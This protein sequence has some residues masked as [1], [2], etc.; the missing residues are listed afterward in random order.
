MLVTRLPP[1]RVR[2]MARKTY[3][4]MFDETGMITDEAV[5][6]AS[7]EI[8]MNLDAPGLRSLNALINRYPHPQAFHDV[9][10]NIYEHDCVYT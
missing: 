7:R 2:A 4:Q 6:Y 8:A 5:D 1:K 10:Q 9:P 3:S